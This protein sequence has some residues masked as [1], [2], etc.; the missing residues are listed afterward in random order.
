MTN[1]DEIDRLIGELVTPE[2][3]AE[4]RQAYAAA[5]EAPDTTSPPEYWRA[6]EE[7][8]KALIDVY[9]R[10]IAA[11]PGEDLIHQLLYD[12]L[13]YRNGEKLQAA[14][15]QQLGVLRRDR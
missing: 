2:L 3:V 12:A 7:R 1:P 6:R 11:W 10:I 8:Q 4:A 13:S 15:N 9:V 14:S 5:M